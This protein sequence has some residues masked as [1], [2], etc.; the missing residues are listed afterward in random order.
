MQVNTATNH[1]KEKQVW[2][3]RYW[4]HLIQDEHDWRSHMDY[5]HYNPVKHDLVYAPEDWEHSSFDYWVEKGLY[6]KNWGAGE[7]IIFTG[8]DRAE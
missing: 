7:D 1:R 8:F 4:E 2:Q 5:I 6:D 3:R